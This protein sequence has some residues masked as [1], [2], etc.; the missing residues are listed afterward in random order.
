[1]LM[2]L[3]GTGEKERNVQKDTISNDVKKVKNKDEENKSEQKKKN[4]T[5]AKLL[6][7]WV[8]DDLVPEDWIL[9]EEFKGDP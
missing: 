1:M 5:V 6:C 4:P 3:E 7:G 2:L 9:K 8:E